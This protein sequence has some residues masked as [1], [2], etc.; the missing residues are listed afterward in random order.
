MA[1]LLAIVQ[2]ATVTNLGQRLYA[3]GNAKTGIGRKRPL[4]GSSGTLFCT[5]VADASLAI[6]R[7]D[8]EKVR[9]DDA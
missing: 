3:T 4:E 8:F 5:T 6:L 7:R 9:Y 2:P 1:A